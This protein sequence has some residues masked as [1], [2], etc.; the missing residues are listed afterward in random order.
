[1]LGGTWPACEEAPGEKVLLHGK[2]YKLYRGMGSLG[3]MAP[4]GKKSYSK[5]RYFQAGRDQQRQ[6]HSGGRRGR[7]VPYRGPL[8]AV[9]YQMI[10]GLHQSMFY[11][12]AHN[13]KEMS[14]RGRF[15]RITDAGLRESHPHDIVMTA[16]APNYSGFHAN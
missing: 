8:N 16:E 5:D 4:R 3:A 6:G 2:Q 13:I 9:L 12:G 1:M 14:E 11:I 15:V 7:R 10:G